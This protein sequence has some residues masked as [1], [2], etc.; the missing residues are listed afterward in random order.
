[1]ELLLIF[2]VAVAGYFLLKGNHERGKRFV[3]AH[4]FLMKLDSG[5][6]VEEA[7]RLAKFILTEYLNADENHQAIMRANA[8][9]RAYAYAREKYNGKQ[10]PVIAEAISRGFEGAKLNKFEQTAANDSAVSRLG[11]ETGQLA[12]MQLALPFL[13]GNSREMQ[14]FTPPDGFFDD[15]FIAGYIMSFINTLRIHGLSDNNLTEDQISKFTQSALEAVDKNLIGS[16]LSKSWVGKLRNNIND[17]RASEGADASSALVLAMIGKIDENYD[18]KLISDAR[19]FSKT[20]KET[21]SD[22]HKFTF[23]ENDF[24]NPTSTA[25]VSAIHE[26]TVGRYMKERYPKLCYPGSNP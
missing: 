4:Y 22:L 26:I 2:G 16:D 5:E 17:S 3:R 23:M 13:S 9:T 15:P 14:R 6:S 24:M 20:R 12:L 7:N 18:N 25:L 19:E 10:L 11:H 8:Y 1:M 21:M